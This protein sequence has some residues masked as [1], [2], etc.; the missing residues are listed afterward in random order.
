MRN[1]TRCNGSGQREYLN[2]ITECSFCDGKG[3]FPEVDERLIRGLIIANQGKN[4][5]K[6]RASMVSPLS[7]EGVVKARAYYVWRIARFHGGVDMTMPITAEMLVYGDPYRE[8]LEK[9]A[10]IVAMENYG[11]DLAAARRWGR[12]FGMI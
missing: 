2:K 12:A 10:G 8:D 9:L 4:K 6:L 11:T 3:S 1:C 7:K 5:G